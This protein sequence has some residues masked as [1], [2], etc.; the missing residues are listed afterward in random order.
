[1]ENS[2]KEYAEQMNTLNLHLKGLNTIYEIQLKDISSQ[3]HTI[4]CINQ[5]LLNIKAMYEGS[6]NDNDRFVKET[7]AMAGNL[8]SLNQIYARMLQAM[9]SGQAFGS[10]PQGNQQNNNETSN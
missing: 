9:M 3:I 7:E 1:M 4:D 2:L 6:A 8:S 10:M 5:S